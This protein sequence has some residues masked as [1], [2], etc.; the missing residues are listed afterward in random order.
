M[1]DVRQ[2]DQTR[3]RHPLAQIFFQFML[4]LFL[5]GQRH[6]GEPVTRQ[7]HQIMATFDLEK[8]DQLGASRRLADPGQR[9]LAGDGIYRG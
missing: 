5:D 6:L 9:F 7:V 1:P 3:Q 8:V 4:P 2:Y